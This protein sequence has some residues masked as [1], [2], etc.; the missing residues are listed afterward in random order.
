MQNP[1]K[2]PKWIGQHTFGLPL[3]WSN[4]KKCSSPA[5]SR[6]SSGSLKSME[7]LQLSRAPASRA[8]IPWEETQKGSAETEPNCQTQAFHLLTPPETNQNMPNSDRFTLKPTGAKV[9]TQRQMGVS[10]LRY[11]ILSR[12]PFSPCLEF[13][14]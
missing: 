10:E 1:S 2:P 4:P 8:P 9:F 6:G 11:E 5:F 7:R 14:S 3:K 12:A 13:P